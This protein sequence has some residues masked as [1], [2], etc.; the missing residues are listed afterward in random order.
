M[1]KPINTEPQD[2]ILTFLA[3]FNQIDKYFD[4]ILW[5]DTFIPY[6]EKIKQLIN[7]QYSISWFVK[8]HQY[9]LRYFGEV[10]NQITHGIKISGHSYV[11]PTEYAIEQLEK[12]AAAIKQPP[13]CKEVFGKKVF[14]VQ[15]Q[16]TLWNLVQQIKKHRYT[17]IPVYTDSY[18]FLGIIVI[19]ELFL[20]IVEKFEHKH[21]WE[22]I[23]M[24]DCPLFND[25][26][27][28]IFVR[29]DKNIYEIDQLFTTRKLAHQSPG[30]ILISYDG[31]KNSEL[32]GI[33]TPSDSA[34]IDSFVIH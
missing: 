14:I 33:I 11:N 18:E 29:G 6:N 30:V 24:K 19:E 2:P 32:M 25:N 15:G 16:D 3:L 17:H 28:V 7:G 23:H 8:L 12:Y 5:L 9:Q 22:N 1:S 27:H 13:Q 21:E 4:K 34:I 20:W 26:A 10:R 31:T